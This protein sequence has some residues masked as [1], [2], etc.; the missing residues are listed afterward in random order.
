MRRISLSILFSLAPILAILFVAQSSCI[1]DDDFLQQE[2]LFFCEN[3]SDCLSN[4]RCDVNN[5]CVFDDGSGPACIDEDGDGYGANTDSRE[6]CENG[7]LDSDDN[8]AE[9]YPGA[10]ELC[11]TKD[12]DGD[13]DID[14]PIPCPSGTAADCPF[15]I[16]VPGAQ[17]RCIN[18]ECALTP[19]NFV[20]E[21]E[22]VVIPCV[23]GVGSPY[24]TT[25]ATMKGCL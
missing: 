12:N 10:E 18:N 19:A 11:D 6:N 15:S 3:D 22:G 1:L 24:D 7:E 23:G 5:T 16:P 21:C 25:E 20:G 4:Y 9:C 17:W 14:E 2:S 8:C 13:M